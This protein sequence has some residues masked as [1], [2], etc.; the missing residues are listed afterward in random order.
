MCVTLSVLIVDDSRSF[1]DAA[2][3]L[4]ER[5]GV[6]IVGL[7]SSSAEALRQAAELH[8]EVIL[9]DITLAGES[10]F[11]LARQLAEQRR[12]AAVMILISTHPQADFADLIE[13]SP[14]AGF[15]SKS[16]L[17]AGAIRQIAGG[18]PGAHVR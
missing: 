2:R 14:A 8:P 15:L 4:L 1:L 17:S 12:G 5:Q 3:D 18:M 7:V 11:D 10:G 9:I 6:R 13:E 16:E